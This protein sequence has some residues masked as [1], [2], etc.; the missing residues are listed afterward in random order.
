MQR[1]IL[2]RFLQSLLAL[3]VLSVVVFFATWATGNPVDFILPPQETTFEEKEALKEKLGLDRPVGL[4]YITYLGRVFRGDFGFALMHGRLPVT[5]VIGN[6]L[7]NTLHLGAMAFILTIAVAFPLGVFAAYN[8]GKLVDAFSRTLAFAGQSIP[9]FWLALV[10]IYTF[11]VWWELLP[12]AGREGGWSHWILP[13]ITASWNSLA[14]LLRIT[15]SSVLEVLG[16]DYIRTAR[17]KGLM[18]R[19]V[20]WRH[21]LKNSLIPVITSVALLSVGMLNGIVLVEIVF[22]WPGLGQLAIDSVLSRDLFLVQALTLMAGTA[23]LS[24]NFFADVMYS[25]VDPR[26]R[27]D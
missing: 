20:L 14:G 8:R 11:G 17:A 26:V 13:A 3:F 9:E 27:Y 6:R 23:F 19:T 10:L 1:F 18:E 15:R 22:A 21:T 5:T 4:Q 7:P 24:A 12:V 2:I 16:S 25:L